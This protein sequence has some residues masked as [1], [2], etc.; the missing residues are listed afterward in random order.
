MYHC[1]ATTLQFKKK[2]FLIT[3]EGGEGGGQGEEQERKGGEGWG[4][5][6]EARGQRRG[7]TLSFRDSGIVSCDS[8]VSSPCSQQDGDTLI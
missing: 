1:M 8:Y 6:G 3:K 5:A 7:K 2:S 4:R